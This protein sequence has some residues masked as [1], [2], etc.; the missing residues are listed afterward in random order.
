[1]RQDNRDGTVFSPV[2]MAKLETERIINWMQ[3]T[4]NS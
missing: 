1:M 3:K 2:H 4:E